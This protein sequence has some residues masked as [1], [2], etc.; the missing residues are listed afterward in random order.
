MPRVII[1]ITVSDGKQDYSYDYVE[2]K[3]KEAG[4]AINKITRGYHNKM[5]YYCWP[6]Y[7][8]SHGGRLHVCCSRGSG[9]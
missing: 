5:I 3:E 7:W 1:R 2:V 6:F 9:P 8:Y 4:T